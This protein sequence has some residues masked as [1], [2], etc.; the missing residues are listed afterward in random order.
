MQSPTPILKL[1]AKL[2]LLGIFGLLPVF[3]LADTVPVASVPT[4]TG[5]TQQVADSASAA[6]KKSAEAATKA[7]D[8]Q[9]AL[10]L[11]ERYIIQ[12]PGD[13][14]AHRMRG[15][16]LQEIGRSDEAIAAYR[17]SAELAPNDKN[18]WIGLCW[19]Q[20][21]LNRPLEARPNCEKAVA[22]DKSNR[23]A[24]VNLGRTFL[25]AGDTNRSAL[26]NLGHT[27]LLAGD[28]KLADHWYR[29]SLS[30]IGNESD[31]RDGPLA[32]FD[33]FIGKDWQTEESGKARTWFVQAWPQWQE[34]QRLK[35]E[36]DQL[37]TAGRYQEALPLAERSLALAV[38]CL[39]DE[40]RLTA[41]R[42]DDVGGLLYFTGQ[43]VRAEPLYVRALA[44]SEKANGAEHPYT[45]ARLNNLAL[46]YKTTGQ[47]ARAEPL[48]VRAL[49]ISEKT[50]GA[51]HPS[52]G[53]RLNNLAALYQSMG[54]YA[55]AEPLYVRALAISE[56]A[57]GAEHPS[58][59]T[60]LNNLAGLY[61]AMG[62]Y[63]R[64]EPLYARSLAI[65]EKA[66]G[67]EHP[68]TGRSLNNMALLYQSMGQYARAEPLFIR[69]LAIF[70]KAVGSEH[71]S[72]G[73]SLNNLAQLYKS[74]GQY[75]RAEPLLVRALAISER[76]EGAE[77]PSTGRALN[78]LAGLYRAMGQS[79]RAE[80]LYLRA[81]RIAARAGDPELSWNVQNSLR[82]F[83][84]DSKP[85]L[86]IWYGKQAVNTLQSVRADNTALDKATQKSFLE[87][88]ETTYK[89]L[90]DL[91]FAQGRLMEGQQVL[92]MLKEAEYFDF[93]QRSATDDPRQTH[94]GFDGSEQ[95]WTARYATIS[96]KLAALSREHEALAKKDE[97]G[98]SASEKS[99]LAQLEADL[100]VARQAYDVF[101][102]ELIRELGKTAGA[103][104]MKDVGGKNLED[105]SILQ[106]ALGKLGHGAVTLHYLMTDKRL[107]ILLTTPTIQLK[108]ESAIGEAE[109]NRQIG[110]YRE[111]IARRD[112][113]V[114][115]LGKALYDLLVAP[116]ADDLKQ[117]EAQTLMLSLDGALRY[118]PM[119]AL[120]DGERFLAQ[121]YQL[122]I[123]TSAATLTLKDQP[124]AKWKFAAF[125]LTQK[126][127]NFSA[128]PSVRAELEGMAAD[129]FTG[130]VRFDGDFTAA[131]LKSGLA[132]RPPVVHLASHFK[133]TPGNEADSF[134]LMGDGKPL[135]LKD[136]KDGG[137]KFTDVDLV[138]LSAC[139]T[140][141][142]GGKDA[143]GREIEGFGALAQ[144]QGAKG[145]IATL[146]PVAD[147][148]TG[149]FMQLFYGFRQKNPGMTKAEAMRKAQQ[150]FIK[151]KV[152]QAL[153][154]IDRGAKRADAGTDAAPLAAVTTT[155]HPFFWAPFILMGN[156][157]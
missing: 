79:T 56:K 59:G 63:L 6:L 42:M 24:L 147:Q 142:G 148:S 33:L 110:A 97:A 93:I 58:T 140:A 22:L 74:M 23:A 10:I 68:S 149:Q 86:A 138:T 131:T 128:L 80:P 112:P 119:A 18:T 121:R 155:D 7:K 106:D 105:L 54:Q 85:E 146:W 27:F 122:A 130:E 21:I 49:A 126:V 132:K 17:K 134:L 15:R 64:A 70:E 96:S 48:Y 65:S 30:T 157:L 141:V 11:W 129:G 61:E 39:G 84:A 44:I 113:K 95:P 51:E 108:R 81:W 118:L 20:V 139:E 9:Q 50:E 150:A 116:V 143:N 66:E 57:N 133:F 87:R 62:Q 19:T 91:L 14:T 76:A 1:S 83:Y 153:A 77:H 104:R 73:W 82:S 127:E 2:L 53:I 137:F 94:I 78:N 5:Q 107:W 144:K 55:R 72:T 8:W 4:P 136:I 99:R 26:V 98:L 120:Y 32:D 117:A 35:R 88:N 34:A 3:A 47:Y 154:Q 40:H 46:L 92:A 135:S 52:T 101:V 71:P 152:P 89:S 124:Q 125:G 43:Y 36:A 29:E 103:E 41:I 111:A 100:T 12:K 28:A 13:A 16:S 109:L 115:Q 102:A 151:G 69:T 37:K 123:Y 45:S 38:K 60:N 156:W 25:V 67:A 145:V 75:A 90:A 31:L 114:K